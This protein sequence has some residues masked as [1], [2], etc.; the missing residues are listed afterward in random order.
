VQKVC[1]DPAVHAEVPASGQDQQLTPDGKVKSLSLPFGFD[2]LLIEALKGQQRLLKGQGA[3]LAALR[4]ELAAQREVNRQ[5][6]MRL[7]AIE[8]AL[9][10]L[11]GESI[12]S[13]PPAE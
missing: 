13:S 5:K 4:R 10:R 1:S 3:E 8:K 6:Q 12:D 7:E 11:T 2:A 9:N